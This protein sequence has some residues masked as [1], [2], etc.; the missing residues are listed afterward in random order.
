MSFNKHQLNVNRRKV[1][2]VNKSYK[3]ELN[4]SLQKS[5]ELS[6]SRDSTTCLGA[7]PKDP[8]SSQTAK[9]KIILM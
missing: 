2:R 9:N 4:A 7:T 5:R 8:N 6:V 3:L 1:L